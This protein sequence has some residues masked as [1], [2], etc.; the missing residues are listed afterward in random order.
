MFN[1]SKVNKNQ[2]KSRV[3]KRILRKRVK[4]R[5]INNLMFFQLM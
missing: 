2:Q 4:K 3:S 1:N 5:S